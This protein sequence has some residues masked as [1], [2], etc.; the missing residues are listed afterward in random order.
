MSST[1]DGTYTKCTM[2][3]KFIEGHIQV[4]EY[5]LFMIRDLISEKG[6][7]TE[8][9]QTVID[10]ALEELGGWYEMREMFS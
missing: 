10:K 9:V 5:I 4:Q 7:T 8:E 1:G 2:G 6:E 3:S